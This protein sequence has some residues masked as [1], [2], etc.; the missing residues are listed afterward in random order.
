MKN[1][2]IEMYLSSFIYESVEFSEKNL[3]G[4]TVCIVYLMQNNDLR[5]EKNR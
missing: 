1:Y 5:H 2:K 4:A 3:Y